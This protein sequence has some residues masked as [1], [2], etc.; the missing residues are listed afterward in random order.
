LIIFLDEQDF[1]MRTEV[2]GEKQRCVERGTRCRRDRERDEYIL[3]RHLWG[4]QPFL[5]GPSPLLGLALHGRRSPGEA[6][7]DPASRQLPSPVHTVL[8]FPEYIATSG[9]ETKAQTILDAINQRI[10]VSFDEIQKMLTKQK[11]CDPVC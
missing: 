1:D 5:K 3:D 2:P 10:S 4:P 7:N 8:H 11:E 9:K 6:L